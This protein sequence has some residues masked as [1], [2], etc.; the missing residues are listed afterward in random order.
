MAQVIDAQGKPV[1]EQETPEAFSGP[2]DG[3]ANAVFRAV[4]RELANPR[5][6]TDHHVEHGRRREISQQSLD[7][8]AATDDIARPR[9]AVGQRLLE[10]IAD[11]ADALGRIATRTKDAHEYAVA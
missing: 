4:F 8:R 1:R 5:A 3:K 6:G 2:T 7:P 11:A 10:E 9:P